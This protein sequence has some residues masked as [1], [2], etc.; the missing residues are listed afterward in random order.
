MRHTPDAAR[1]LSTPVG[2]E[3]FVPMFKVSIA[4]LATVCCATAASAQSNVSIGYEY[5]RLSISG[6]PFSLREGFGAT[7][8][9]AISGRWQAIG[10][11]DWARKNMSGLVDAYMMG[12]TFTQ[13]T[14]GGGVRREFETGIN[15]HPYA[16][17]VAGI[18]RSSVRITS[19]GAVAIDSSSN[20]LLVEPG[21]GLA[22]ELTRRL[23]IFGE[24]GYRAIW[25]HADSDVYFFDTVRGLRVL[26]GARVKVQ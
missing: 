16:Q 14:L 1:L 11:V 18:A 4:A 21:A 20:D 19:N 15:A 9:V 7:Y 17:A 5:V 25:P 2:A 23:G 12:E 22:L 13:T 26:V 24:I 6:E 10:S 8:A 3:T